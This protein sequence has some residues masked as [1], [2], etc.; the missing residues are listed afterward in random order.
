MFFL[1]LFLTS[2]PCEHAVEARTHSPAAETTVA[3]RA[4]LHHLRSAEE[5][6]HALRAEKEDCAADVVVWRYIVC[7]RLFGYV[8]LLIVLYVYV[9]QCLLAVVWICFCAVLIVLYVYVF[10]G[11]C[12]DVLCV[13]CT[14]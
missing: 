14:S 7:L 3:G 2:S 12:L 11:G 8:L 6:R 9:V 5:Q 1:S 4:P 10:V 13:V